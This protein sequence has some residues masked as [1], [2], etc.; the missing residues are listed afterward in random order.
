MAKGLF[1]LRVRQ[2][3]PSADGQFGLTMT[4]EDYHGLLA[5]NMHGPSTR[6]AKARA[7][8]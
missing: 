6:C 2:F 7:T 1:D 3:G 5:V 4:T 8:W